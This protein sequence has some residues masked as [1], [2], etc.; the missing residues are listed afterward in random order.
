MSQTNVRTNIVGEGIS[1]TVIVL[2]YTE[3]EHPYFQGI[4]GAAFP[5]RGFHLFKK[6][7]YVSEALPRKSKISKSCPYFL[8]T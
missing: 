5:E 4:Q 3:G 1:K 7:V 8:Y 6:K 2:K